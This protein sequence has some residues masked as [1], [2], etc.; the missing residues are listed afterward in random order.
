MTSS[1]CLPLRKT[2]QLRA[3]PSSKRF[4]TIHSEYQ[5]SSPPHLQGKGI[6]LKETP[7]PEVGENEVLIRVRAIGINPIDVASELNLFSSFWVGAHH[8]PNRASLH[9]RYLAHK[10]FPTEGA[11]TGCDFT[12][13]VVKL[14]PNLKFGIEIGDRVSATVTGSKSS[15]YPRAHR[16]GRTLLICRNLSS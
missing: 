4:V 1:Q 8:P 15:S 2:S 13:E 12:G 7:T 16:K 3:R 9:A 6:V 14:G 11:Y 5:Q 10:Y